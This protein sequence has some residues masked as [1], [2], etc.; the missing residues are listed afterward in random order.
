M[1]NKP[2]QKKKK[3]FFS[4]NVGQVNSSKTVV[5]FIFIAKLDSFLLHF[6]LEDKFLTRNFS[7]ETW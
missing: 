4:A 3:K 1:K 6:A 7:L 5:R 2:G